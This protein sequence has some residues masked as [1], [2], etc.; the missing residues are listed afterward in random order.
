[1]LNLKDWL[2]ISLYEINQISNDRPIAVKELGVE[3]QGQQ[4]RF[5]RHSHLGIGLVSTKPLIKDGQIELFILANGDHM[6]PDSRGLIQRD[7]KDITDFWYNF[8]VC[9]SAYFGSGNPKPGRRRGPTGSRRFDTAGDLRA[10][11]PPVKSC[12]P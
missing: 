7:E 2:R 12:S 6:P 5:A 9:L 10:A 11:T 3:R 4:D 1:M 8:H